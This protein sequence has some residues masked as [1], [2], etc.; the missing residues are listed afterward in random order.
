MRRPVF[1]MAAAYAFGIYGAFLFEFPWFV[2]SL[3][4]AALGGA[5][6][7]L[8]VD[9]RKLLPLYGFFLLGVFMFLAAAHQMDAKS[10]YAGKQA[11][12]RGEV[13]SVSQTK[14]RASLV[15]KTS[16]YGKVLVNIY[17]K[18]PDFIGSVGRWMEVT[19]ILEQAPE[20]GNPGGFDYRLYLRSIGIATIMKAD[21]EH[22]AFSMDP[23]DRVAHAV[24]V[25]RD[26]FET[27]LASSMGEEKAGLAVA[28]LF[29][30]RSGLE[31][32]EY[33][34]FQRN[35]TAHILSVSGLHVGFVYAILMTVIGGKRKLLPNGII[36]II[37]VGYGMLSGFCPSVARALLMIGIHMLSKVL[38][39]QYDLLSS[40]GAAAIILLTL[41]PYCL[42]HSGFQLSFLAVVLMG[43][44]FPFIGGILPHT[45]VL[46]WL[47]PMPLLQAAMAP[48]TAFVFN[49]FSFGAFVANFGVI[50]FSGIL[51]P[52]GLFTML[53]GTC[54][55]TLFELGCIFMDLCIRCVL[56]CNHVTYAGG[57][58]CFD[59][60][61]PSIFGLLLFYGLF[62]FLFSEAGRVLVIRKRTGVIVWILAVIVLTSA[63]LDWRTED[64]FDGADA[65]FVDVG[66]GDCL[67]IRTP[68]G[69]HVLIDGGGKETFDVG[70]KILKPY[71]L[72]NGVNRIDLAIST[73]LDTDHFDGLR[74]L[75]ADGMVRQLGLYAGNRLIETSILEKTG[76]KPEQLSY[77]HQG[78][79]IRVDE[80]VLLEVLYP[81]PKTDRIY[82]EEIQA[83]EENPRSLVIR[84]HLGDCSILMTGDIDIATEKDVVAVQ[85]RDG[86][87]AD[88]LKIAHHGSKYSTSDDFLEKTDPTTAV[89]STGKN[90]YGHP[91][92]SILEKCR[93]KGIMIFRT[94]LNGAIGLFDCYED[95]SPY[96]QTI[97]KGT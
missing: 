38:C 88:I 44:I 85:S 72:K 26:E 59:V 53:A 73:H 18:E 5:A 12:C 89:F 28:M 65:I 61:S 96:F 83:E 11:T 2:W 60:V 64:G 76:L 27:R 37:L 70:K 94:D 68:S 20:A 41:N 62:L 9:R 29:G 93:E 82:R 22:V 13:L 23:V 50:F 6:C 48:Y 45:N 52:A 1:C 69:K 43:W 17:Q 55:T 63:V 49:Y 46:S 16:I 39:R 25:F 66:Q 34:A 71:L 56:W 15:V 51:I 31:E 3:V 86:M 35:G 54:S 90:N 19:G 8:P 92:G 97:R 80:A 58:T 42:F 4:L 81:K 30:D 21:L 47:L 95:A 14:E 77:L 7:L 74:S 57:K 78:D 40:A 91:D 75:A 24:A 36:L 84:V 32:E 33:E 87:K 10:A 79:R 67:H